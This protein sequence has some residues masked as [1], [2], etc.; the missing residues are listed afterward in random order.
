MKGTHILYNIFF[1]VFASLPQNHSPN[2][3]VLAPEGH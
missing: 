1:K 3:W 2:S